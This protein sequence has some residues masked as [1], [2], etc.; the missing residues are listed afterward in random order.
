MC[1]LKSHNGYWYFAKPNVL[2]N[3]MYTI[4]TMT[5]KYTLF[6]LTDCYTSNDE[7][8]DMYTGS[9][10]D[11]TIQSEVNIIIVLL[12]QLIVEMLEPHSE[13]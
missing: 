2:Y 4:G 11:V 9:S 7:N 10:V 6:M 8:P 5:F 13:N 12:K 1:F 3:Y